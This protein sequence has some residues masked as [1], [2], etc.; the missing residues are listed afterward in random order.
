M[1]TAATSASIVFVM[2]GGA[3]E[4][5]NIARSLVS[6]RLA[7]CVNIVGPVHSIYRWR[8]AI[9]EADEHLL[10]IKSRASL[11]AALERRVIELHSYEVPEV[12]ALRIARGSRAYLEWLTASADARPQRISPRARIRQRATR[13]GARQ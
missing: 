5:A 1:A 11:Y 3:A 7:A 8:G 10:V 4:A 13:V 6:E 2:A 12:I 9:E